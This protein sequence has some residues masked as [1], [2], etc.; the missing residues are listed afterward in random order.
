MR[1]VLRWLW[2]FSGGFAVLFFVSGCSGRIGMRTFENDIQSPDPSVRIKAVIYAANARDAR[3]IPLI[4]DRLE[5]EDEAVRISAIE[6]L[7]QMTGQDLGYRSFD[8]PYLRGQAVAR[9]RHW[10][11]E[12]AEKNDK[13]K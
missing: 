2:M 10:L 1:R 7:R 4:I 3:A 6:S 12:M 13:K 11:K 8:P 5:D 9:W